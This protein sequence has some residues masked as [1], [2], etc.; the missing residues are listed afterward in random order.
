[1][2]SAEPTNDAASS[3]MAVDGAITW[4]SAPVIPGV[5]ISATASTVARRLFASRTPSRPTRSGTN[6][7][8]ATSNRPL[9]TPTAA[10]R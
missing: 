9:S 10:A 7:R 8:Y 3:R 6:E 2:H 1:M 5:L 4:T